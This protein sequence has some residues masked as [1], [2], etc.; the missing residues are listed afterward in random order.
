MFR[1]APEQERSEQTTSGRRGVEHTAR[2]QHDENGSEDA[3]HADRERVPDR[4]ED[5]GVA[6]NEQQVARARFGTVGG[7]PRTCLLRV[8][9]E[10]LTERGANN[11][12]VAGRDVDPLEART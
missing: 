6:V 9:K 10:E 12:D 3:V 1:R 4:M 2:D 5:P 7:R 8:Q 11:H